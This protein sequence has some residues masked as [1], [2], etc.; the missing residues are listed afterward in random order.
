[1]GAPQTV[2]RELLEA[3]DAAVLGDRH[4]DIHSLGP[5][6]FFC[7]LSGMEN[8]TD[9]EGLEGGDG[10]AG[11]ERGQIG[12]VGLGEMVVLE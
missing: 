5:Q 4:Q 12:K 2:E 3:G 11:Q 10:D 7:R 6:R 1:M 9:S 8:G